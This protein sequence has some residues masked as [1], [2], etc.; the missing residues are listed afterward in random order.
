MIRTSPWNSSA[1]RGPPAF[2]DFTMSE[3]DRKAIFHNKTDLWIFYIPWLMPELWF[4]QLAIQSCPN[5]FQKRAIKYCDPKL[6]TELPLA[7]NRVPD[8]FYGNEHVLDWH[9]E[10]IPD[11]HGHFSNV[12][13]HLWGSWFY[14]FKAKECFCVMSCVSI[15]ELL[16][17]WRNSLTNHL[18]EWTC[19][20]LPGA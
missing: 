13:C 4:W 11:Q 5:K 17:P 19:S 10:I 7:K 15:T 6:N 16:F 18:D 20:L 9:R 8:G 3:F 1:G 2:G 12:N 14:H